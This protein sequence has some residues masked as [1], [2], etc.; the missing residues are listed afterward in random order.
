MSERCLV[1]TFEALQAM[2]VGAE[3]G[4]YF[5]DRATARKLG[6]PFVPASSVKGV[7]RKALTYYGADNVI[8]T[9]LFGSPGSE[10]ERRLFF[11]DCECLTPCLTEI[12]PGITLNKA[13]GTV[14]EKRLFYT[15]RVAK[16]TRFSCKVC[17]DEESV[18]ILKEFL[19]KPEVRK[20]FYFI[21]LGDAMVKLV[22]VEVVNP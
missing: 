10:D 19:E 11:E 12:R 2:N 18:K 9:K 3:G 16:G 14:M 17:G 22:N 5:V 15:E 7:L 4:R 21:G 6:K 8:I 13:L 1:L 20:L